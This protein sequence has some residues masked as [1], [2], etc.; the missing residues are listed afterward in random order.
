M[1]YT[2]LH[3]S[4]LLSGSGPN[5]WGPPATA[6]LSDGTYL[7][8]SRVQDTLESIRL[9]H[10]AADLTVLGSTDIVMGASDSPTPYLVATGMHAVL[11]TRVAYSP[12]TYAT[13][14]IDA[15]GPTPS[16]GSALPMA[17]SLAPRYDAGV[18]A[19]FYD[20]ATNRI[21]LV[22]TVLQVFSSI[23]GALLSE[24]SG[25]SGPT[26]I[27]MNPADH[28]QFAV[29]DN[30]PRRLNFTVSL[31]GSSCSFDGASAMPGIPTSGIYPG[32]A[33]SPFIA[34]GAGLIAESYSGVYPVNYYAADGSV[35]ASGAG[36]G[37]E[38]V[39]LF[40]PFV[41]LGDGQHLI[42]YAE[43]DLG[44]GSL[45][46]RLFAVD[47]GVVP[48]TMAQ[49]SLPYPAPGYSYVFDIA[50]M[51]AGQTTGIILLG[52][53]LYDRYVTGLVSSVLWVI[54]GPGGGVVVPPPLRQ[55]QRDDGMVGSTFRAGGGT[56]R[57]G[58]IR[59]L[60]YW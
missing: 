18:T 55:F 19:H 38:Y 5:P 28:T 36:V 24:V 21:V 33:G 26:G 48:A 46:G 58:S 20:P 39:N 7:V 51:D 4:V 6:I 11:I 56:S 14:L 59:Q 1:T 53:M 45:E 32:A 54:Q 8:A 37:G 12:A 2:L 23:T 50:H 43:M 35:P 34:G 60:G 42:S 49:L 13:Y 27:Y 52:A 17:T 57:Q 15:T 30:W 22:G 44:G 31:G 10:L 29:F 47:Q 9:W 41:A 16:A 3:S 25:V 40:G